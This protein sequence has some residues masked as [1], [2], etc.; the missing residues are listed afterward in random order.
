MFDICER[1]LSPNPAAAGSNTKPHAG[2]ADWNDGCKNYAARDIWEPIAVH[3]AT[4]S[5]T[6]RCRKPSG[7]ATACGGRCLPVG[8]TDRHAIWPASDYAADG[9]RNA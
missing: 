9:L 8:S 2:Q 7:E 4:R 5:G 3:V 6:M 1:L